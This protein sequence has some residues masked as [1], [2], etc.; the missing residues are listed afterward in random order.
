MNTQQLIALLQSLDPSGTKRVIFQN[1][2]DPI[3]HGDEVDIIGGTANSSE[4]KL[5]NPKN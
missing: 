2:G 5:K 3:N 1:E 4:V